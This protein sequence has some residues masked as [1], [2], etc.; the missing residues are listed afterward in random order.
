[1]SEITNNPSKWAALNTIALWV[2][3]L[4]V[5]GWLIFKPEPS[6]NKDVLERLTVAVDKIGVASENMVQTSIAQRE[7]SETLQKETVL[8]NQRRDNDYGGLYEKYGY[9]G[10]N[11]GATLND[12]YDGQL[13]QPK[14]VNSG[15]LRGD[16]NGASK[17][18]VVQK[19][20]SLPK[21][22][23]H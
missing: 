6:L 7:W 9:P 18:G 20:D 12:I 17:T 11:T 14:G 2:L 3:V 13:Q 5:G 21:G 16:E 15:K 4:I 22:Q 23:S 8:K 10:T 1:M 19:P